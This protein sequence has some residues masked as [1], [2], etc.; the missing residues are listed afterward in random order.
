MFDF[1]VMKKSKNV[2]P[3]F[4]LKNVTNDDDVMDLELSELDCLKRYHSAFRALVTSGIASPLKKP[5]VEEDIGKNIQ[6]TIVDWSANHG[7]QGK[8]LIA[9]VQ[10][11]MSYTVLQV[12]NIRKFIIFL[13]SYPSDT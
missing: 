6:N 4:Q 1:L 5:F 10:T 2:I 11:N 3:A 8:E 13:Y 9:E 7:L 12:Y